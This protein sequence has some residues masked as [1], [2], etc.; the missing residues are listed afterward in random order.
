MNTLL[1]TSHMHTAKNQEPVMAVRMPT[2]TKQYSAVF[3]QLLYA[4]LRR[5][6]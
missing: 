1:N 3:M 4:L 2:I 6:G 5:E